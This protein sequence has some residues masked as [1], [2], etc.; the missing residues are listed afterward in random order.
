MKLY[1]YTGTIHFHSEYSMDGRTPIREIIEAA[2]E[3]GIDFLMLTDHEVLTARERGEEGWNGKVLL[4]VGEEISPLRLNHFLVFGMDRSIARDSYSEEYLREIIGQVRDSGGIGLIA[5]PD[6]EGTEMFHVKQFP[7]ARWD[8]SGYTGMSI[9]DFMTD[10]QSTLKGYWSG[11]AGYFFPAFVLRGPKPVT[12]RRWDDL[13]QERRIIGFGELDNHDSTRKIFGLTFSIFPFRKAFHFVRSHIL[14]SKPFT[15]KSEE[16]IRAVLDAVRQGRI[17]A[18]MEYFAPSKGFQFEISENGREA[19][20]GEDFQLE[21]KAEVKI[22]VPAYGRIRL[23]RNGD[24]CAERLG[25]SLQETITER[26]IYRAEVYLK[27]FGRF[28]PWIFSNPI[29]VR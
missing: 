23:I 5:H 20:T 14:L 4:V 17:Y 27:R 29:H 1:D 24:A 19:C 15:G 6:H 8:L 28:R 12:L 22:T 7:W 16:D 25:F 2:S 10:W 11:L 3:A 13:N 18:A 26:G 9:W 21:A